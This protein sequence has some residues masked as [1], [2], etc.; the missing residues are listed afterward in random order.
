MVEISEET[1]FKMPETPK[2][3]ME[4]AK[5]LKEEG[6]NFFKVK[7]YKKAL[8]KYSKVQLFTKNLISSSGSGEEGQMV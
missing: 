3:M 7:D 5:T 1:K 2:E 4:Y 8:S 6:N